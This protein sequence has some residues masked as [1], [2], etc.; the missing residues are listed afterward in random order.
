MLSKKK[1]TPAFRI[2]GR[3]G[4]VTEISIG[5]YTTIYKHLGPDVDT[6]TCVQFNDK[7]DTLFLDDNGLLQEDLHHWFFLTEGGLMQ[8]VGNAVVLGSNSKTGHSVAPK[9]SL[10]DLKKLVI[11]NE[12]N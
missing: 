11:V 2:D 7:G 5:E 12:L 9:I 6:F 8:F 10:A 3:T 1:L 4:S